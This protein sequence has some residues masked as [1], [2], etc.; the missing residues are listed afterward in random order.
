MQKLTKACKNYC[1]MH[2]KSATVASLNIGKS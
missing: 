1:T 2:E